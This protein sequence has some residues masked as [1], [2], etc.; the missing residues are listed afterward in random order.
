MKRIKKVLMITI[1]SALILL[2]LAVTML[3]PVLTFGQNPPYQGKKITNWKNP[4]IDDR[5]KTVFI[6]ADNQQTE[7]FDMLAPFY[8]FNATE[9]L[10]VFIVA[11]NETPIPL[12]KDLF[13]LPQLTFEEVEKRNLQA[14]VIVIPALSAR[15]DNQD[16]VILRFIKNHM[17]PTTKLISICDGATTAAATGLYDGKPITAHATDYNAVKKHFDKPIWT[18]NVTVTQSGN[19]Y[20]T[21]GV[22]NAVE[23]SL[24]IV[25]QLLGKEVMTKVAAQ[26]NYPHDEIRM[27][28]H[29]I[30][31]TFGN[32]M[33]IVRR[34]IFSKRKKL[35]LLLHNGLNELRFAGMLDTY[36]R[37]FPKAYKTFTLQD[38]IVKTQYGLTFIHTGDNIV[39]PKTDEIHVVMPELLSAE[40]ENYFK[41]FELVKQ[42]P[43]EY[44]IDQCLN[45]IKEQY[46]AHYANIVKITLDYN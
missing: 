15:D 22:S 28:H 30:A 34:V 44:I 24:L 41:E 4:T 32:K 13:V 39:D 3:Q 46:G 12:K 42:N 25:E 18:Q 6:I 33:S 5:K 8:V 16:P 45:N 36:S 43:K 37:T 19:L 38:S 7:L 2:A 26:I 29:S 31:L 9:Q 21:A 20:S 14:A 1:S 11:K 35:G 17:T 40:D 27:K 10:N 23:G